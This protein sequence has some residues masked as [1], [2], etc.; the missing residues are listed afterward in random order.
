MSARVESLLAQAI[1]ADKTYLRTVER[2]GEGFEDLRG[3]IESRIELFEGLADERRLE[4]TA[5][6]DVVDR[7]TATSIAHNI[8]YA[9]REA[10][11]RFSHE[12]ADRLASRFAEALILP[13]ATADLAVEIWKGMSE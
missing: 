12:D 4:Q 11:R 13:Q 10:G 2:E 1:H 3:S 9:E 8:V 5:G 7:L 6:A